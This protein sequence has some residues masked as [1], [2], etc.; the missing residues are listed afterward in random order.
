MIGQFDHWVTPYAKDL[1]LAS[2]N[3][4]TPLALFLSPTRRGASRTSSGCRSA[5]PARRTLRRHEAG[6]AAAFAEAR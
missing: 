5:P 2:L 3:S 4:V 6:S 1:E